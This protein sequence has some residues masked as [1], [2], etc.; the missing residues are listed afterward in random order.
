[1]P[2]VP[3]RF[4]AA[5]LSLSAL[6]VPVVAA[7]P[8]QA[9]TTPVITSVKVTS[10]TVTMSNR[11]TSTITVSIS[12]PANVMSGEF[13]S[14]YF[15]VT[16]AATTSGVYNHI[17]WPIT[18]KR[19]VDTSNVD[20]WRATS[21]AL[22]NSADDWG[23]YS[24]VVSVEVDNFETNEVWNLTKVRTTLQVR[25]NAIVKGDAGPEPARRGSAITVSGSL[26]GFNGDDYRPGYTR[27]GAGVPIRIYWRKGTS[28]SFGYMGTALTTS[29]GTFSKRF[30]ARASG[31]WYVR[32]LGNAFHVPSASAPDYVVVR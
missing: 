11:P 27:A 12:D 30:T 14:V 22:S 9:A 25:G 1:M 17:Y 5:A 3:G 13:T 4:V 23:S 19:I 32:Y 2:R 21:D 31:Q 29:K 7:A 18:F 20:V 26:S 6:L 24:V 15:D 16:A 28:G 8:A 10:P